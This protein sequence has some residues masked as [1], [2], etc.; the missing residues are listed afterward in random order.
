MTREGLM[1]KAANGEYSALSESVAQLGGDIRQVSQH[2]SAAANRAVEDVT[3]LGTD[4]L[5]ELQ[6]VGQEY[7]SALEKFATNKPI[8]AIGIGVLAGFL[9]GRFLFGRS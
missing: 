3:Q 8:Q 5:G 6:G 9:A 4:K 7:V 1:T 2:I